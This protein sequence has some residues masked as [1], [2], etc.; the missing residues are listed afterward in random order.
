VFFPT[1]NKIPKKDGKFA[2][3]KKKNDSIRYSISEFSSRNQSMSHSF[4]AFHRLHIK[5]LAA[6]FLLAAPGALFAAD[7]TV[8]P[9]GFGLVSADGQ[10]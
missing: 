7:G 2:I 3:P 6:A 5:P 4:K 1:I 9:S 8:K 10:S